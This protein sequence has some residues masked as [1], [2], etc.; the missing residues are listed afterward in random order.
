M[1][2]RKLLNFW[3]G[4]NR[5][6][7]YVFLGIAAACT[8]L[9]GIALD[10]PETQALSRTLQRAGYFSFLVIVPACFIHWNLHAVHWFLDHFKDTDHL[11]KKQ[12]SLVN[13]FSMTIFLTLTLGALPLSAFCLKPLWQIIARWFADKTSLDKAVYPALHMEMEPVQ[14]PDL[15][16]LFGEAKPTPPW[17]LLLDRLFRA[18][19]TLILGLLMILALIYLLGRL[20]SWITKPRHF[21]SDEKIYLTPTWS[22]TGSPKAAQIKQKKRKGLRQSYDRKI[23]HLYRREILSR[24]SKKKQTPALSASPEE[25]EQAVGLS[26]PALHTLYEKARYSQNGCARADWEVLSREGRAAP[27][28]EV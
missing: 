4:K 12:I 24:Y 5:S 27:T 21:D 17:L 14:A 20:W 25:L 26:R 22:L 16:A 13:S 6:G 2:T 18:V 10:S 23:R 8:N 19:G 9:T 7:F 15:S 28:S 1:T 3:Y 11:P